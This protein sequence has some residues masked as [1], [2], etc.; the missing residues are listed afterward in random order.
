MSWGSPSQSQVTQFKLSD[1][2]I[3]T[4]LVKIIAIKTGIGIIPAADAILSDVHVTGDSLYI[5]GYRN[6]MPFIGPRS[7]TGTSRIVFD[8]VHT[9]SIIN[10]GDV[11]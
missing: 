5:K 8:K 11:H 6:L 3:D 9:I 2:P 10:Q 1:L 4:P 7:T